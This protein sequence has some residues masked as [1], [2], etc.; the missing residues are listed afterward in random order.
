MNFSQVHE[1]HLDYNFEVT[2]LQ[3][4]EIDRLCEVVWAIQVSLNFSQ[5][6]NVN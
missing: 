6:K 3:E 1:W 4:F 2:N 5:Q